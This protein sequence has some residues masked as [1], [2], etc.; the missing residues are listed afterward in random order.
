MGNGGAP[1]APIHLYHA[2]SD[3]EL[4]PFHYTQTLYD[5]GCAGG[6]SIQFTQEALGEHISVALTGAAGALKFL[7]DR[8]DG[9]PAP[10]TCQSQKVVTSALEP[11]NIE[12]LGSISFSV[13]AALLETPL[14]PQAWLTNGGN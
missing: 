4:P 11:A 10:A 2:I 14:G 6:T 8:V 5:K 7:I 1:K 3:D 13:M 9:K 12:V